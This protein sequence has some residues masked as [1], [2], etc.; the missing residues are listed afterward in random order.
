[1]GSRTAWRAEGHLTRRCCFFQADPGSFRLIIPP[2]MA[3]VY[4]FSV[5]SCTRMTCC[6]VFTD[7]GTAVDVLLQTNLIQLVK[8]LFCGSFWEGRALITMDQERQRDLIERQHIHVCVQPGGLLDAHPR[9]FT[10][11]FFCVLL[12]A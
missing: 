10:V 12:R 8:S 11:T 4:F 6:E 1:M 2:V 7:C 5:L 9:L 3:K